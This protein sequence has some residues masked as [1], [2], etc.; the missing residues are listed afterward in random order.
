MRLIPSPLKM[1]LGEGDSTPANPSV[2]PCCSPFGKCWRNEIGSR[3]PHALGFLDLCDFLGI[4]CS[5]AKS[6]PRFPRAMALRQPRVSAWLGL[7]FCRRILLLALLGCAGYWLH[8]CPELIISFKKIAVV[9]N[10]LP[11]SMIPVL[12]RQRLH[13]RAGGLCAGK[14]GFAG[15]PIFGKCGVRAAIST[16]SPAFLAM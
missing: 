9:Q 8:L 4:S 1:K 14:H 16:G 7:Q 2:V 15:C 5:V 10:P 3:T 13:A 11:S 6:R 12:E